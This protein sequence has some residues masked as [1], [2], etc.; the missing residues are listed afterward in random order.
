MSPSDIVAAIAPVVAALKRLGVSYYLGGSVA[1]SAYGIPRST[2]DV[3]LVAELA[4]KHVGPLVEALRETYYVS[5]PAVSDAIARRS[6][7]NVIHLATSFKVDVFAVKNRPYDR[8]ALQRAQSS[9][10]DP[11]HPS[12]EFLLAAPEDVVLSKLEWYRRGDEVAQQQ[13]R[14]VLGVMKVQQNSLDRKYLQQWAAELGV[15]D[16]LQRAWGEAET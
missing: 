8:V 5:A 13:W 9:S 11:E 15:A 12:E 2:L 10:V 6:S 1:S 3:D 16:L 4:P 14:D 7:F